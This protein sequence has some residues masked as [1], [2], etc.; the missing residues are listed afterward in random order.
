[1]KIE[2][3]RLLLLAS[4][5][6]G[7]LQAGVALARDMASEAQDQSPSEA[8][9]AADDVSTEA[10]IVT[11]TLLRGVAPTGTNVISVTPRDIVSTGATST[12]DLLATIPQMGSFNSPP[13][14]SSGTNTQSTSNRPRLRNIGSPYAGGSATLVL[15]DGHRVVGAGIRQ[16]TPDPDIVPPS[17]IERVEVIPDGGSS[18]YGA[19]AV[20]GVINFITR[21]RVDGVEAEARYGAGQD[22]HTVDAALTAGKAWRTGSIYAAYNYAYNNQLLGR[23]RDFIKRIDWNTGLPLGLNC[24]PGNVT[25]RPASGAVTYALPARVANTVNRCDYSDLEAF[26]PQQRRHSVFAGLSQDFGETVKFD[27]RGFYTRR[28]TFSTEGPHQ[29]PSASITPSN[30]FYVNI[31]GPTSGLTQVVAFNWLPVFGPAADNDVTRLETWG[32]TPT[33]SVDLDDNWQLRTLVNYGR[34]NTRFDNPGLNPTLLNAALRGTTVNTAINP[35][36]IGSTPN[37]QLLADIGNYEFYGEAKQ[38]MFNARALVDGTL[39]AMPGGGVKLAVGA[40]YLRETFT[41]RTANIVPGSEGTLPWLSASRSVKSLFG[42]LLVPIFG[43]ENGG[44]G[45]RAL[46]LSFSGRYDKYSDFGE[47]FNPKIGVT[48]KPFDWMTLR[49]NW[50]KSYQ[51]PSLADSKAAVNSVSVFPF[52]IVPNP[53]QPPT[54]ND[55]PYVALQGGFP[56]LR[57]QKA[58]TYSIGAEIKP[59]VIPGLTLGLTYYNIDFKDL[60][61]IPPLGDARLFFSSYTDNFIM[62]PS[63]AQLEALASQIPGG[64]DVVRGAALYGPGKPPVYAVVDIRRTNLSRV[65]LDGIDFSAVYQRSTGFGSIDL[66]VQGNY[67]LNRKT[68]RVV[69]LPFSDDL[70]TGNSRFNLVT[71]VGADIGQFRAQLRWYHNGGFALDPLPSTAFQRHVGAFNVVDLFFRYDVK[72]SGLMQDLSFTLNIDNVFNTDPPVWKSSDTVTAG[73]LNGFTVGRVFQFGVRKKF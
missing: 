24:N 71:T 43:V 20:A 21:R 56:N 48:Y 49:G 53:L 65:K 50:G 25:I 52:P 73:Y 40:E 10:I 15:L 70:A 58:N 6:I 46:S 66:S 69:T 22:Y 23:D 19:D 39:F 35:Y 26:A 51:A 5:C 11:G 72:G 62:N 47:T 64:L 60:I 8:T 34:S 14:I 17:L 37:E 33:L 61:D 41:T 1:M 55:Q 36:D 57:P 44:D 59:P 7:S 32:F 18:T 13:Q 4:S 68:Q 45:Y 28:D 27:L 67:Q 63:Q 16:T 30:P 29:T 3:V 12:N 9:G 38:K 54:S 42:E 31:P 2:K